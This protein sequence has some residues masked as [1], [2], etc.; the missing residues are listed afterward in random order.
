MDRS[1]F[2]ILF[3]EY[4]ERLV[5]FAESYVA[6]MC[7]AED[8]V[9][10]VFVALLMRDKLDDVGHIRSYLFSCVKNECISY[11]RRLKVEDPLDEKLFDAAYYLG[12][13]D[14]LE[15]EGLLQRVEDAVES[16]SEQRREIVKLSIYKGMSYTR[17]AERMSISVNTVKTHIRKAYQD[18]REKLSDDHFNLILPFL[19]W[20]LIGK[21][22][23]I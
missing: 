11:L 19:I 21:N 23:N 3:K 9:Q 14:V 22:S 4:Y 1:K 2:D 20:R 17:I 8:M 6:D 13:F 18:L 7:T 15:R 12:D 10:D 16:L 5:L